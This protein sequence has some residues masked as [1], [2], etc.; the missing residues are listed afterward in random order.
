MQILIFSYWPNFASENISMSDR[1]VWWRETSD[2]KPI[3]RVIIKH[4]GGK[5]PNYNSK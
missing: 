1:N 2:D 3:W 4:Q 5:K